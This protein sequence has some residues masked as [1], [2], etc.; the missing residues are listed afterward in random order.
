MLPV[1]VRNTSDIVQAY[2][3]EVVGVPAS[4]A[5]VEPPTL[6]LY[7]GT[8]GTATVSL[9][10]P[11]GSDLRAGDYPM[12]V[13]VTPTESPDD[14]V[15]PETT[16]RVLPFLETT[17]ELIPRTSKGRRGATH[18]L[19]IDNRGN[20]PIKC[21]IAGDD[22]NQA[23]TFDEAPQSID[24]GPGE[25]K[26]ATVRVKPGQRLWRGAA[27]T[28]PFRVT[29][30]PQDGAPVV[31]DGT[32]LQEPLIP[33][34]FWKALLGLLLL[35]LLLL[36]LWFWLLRPTI[37][38]AAKDA[39]AED[40]EAAAAAAEA[41]E[42]EAAAASGQAEN[43]E[44][45]AQAAQDQAVAAQDAAAEAADIAGITRPQ[46]DFIESNEA[47]RISTTVTG[48]GNSNSTIGFTLGEG[49]TFDITDVVFE[50]P[51]GD[52]GI[53]ELTV[54]GSPVLALGAENFRALDYH[55]VTPIVVSENEPVGLSVSCTTPGTGPSAPAGNTQ[56][57]ISAL[58]S[59]LLTVPNPE[60]EAAP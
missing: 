21:F 38:S 30:T 3:I 35:L 45:A 23:L 16:I 2:E 11:R 60:A 39:V 42:E 52:I 48:A 55:F 5:T 24:V 25:A 36:A 20:I 53:V 51:N 58:I 17:A 12:G 9:A 8:S 6:N 1:E 10:P 15:V 29:V 13:K 22:D 47:R 26:F 14:A 31:L 46:P 56:C 4:F 37:E 7:P 19:A 59:G 41:A 44:N 50:N 33:P 57:R 28:H 27:R 40:V 54:D 49:E 32:H 34:W 43:A 18:D